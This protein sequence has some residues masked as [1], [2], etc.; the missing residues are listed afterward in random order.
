[1]KKF[2]GIGL[3]V[4]VVGGGLGFM[5]QQS[6]T[7]TMMDP[8]T[9]EPAGSLPSAPD[10]TL[11]GLDGSSVRLSDFRGKKAVLLNFW[12]TWCPNCREEI[13]ELA[14][15][16]TKYQDRDFVVLGIDVQEPATRVSSY[17]K[18]SP[19]NYQ[20]VLDE[21][22]WVSDAYKVYGIPTSIFINKEGKQVFITNGLYREH[23]RMIEETLGS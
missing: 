18:K 9:S 8:M 23:I 14:Q 4:L 21:D 10:F 1:M 17:V 3:L 19:I 6:Q 16:M 15:I 2:V 20:I 12:A 13:P 5:Y 22:G 7:K 11:A